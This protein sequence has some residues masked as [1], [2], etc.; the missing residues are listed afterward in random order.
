MSLFKLIK[1]TRYW[2]CLVESTIIIVDS[3]RHS[4]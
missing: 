3:T 2:E 4:Q 1:A